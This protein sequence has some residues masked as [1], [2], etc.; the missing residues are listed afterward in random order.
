MFEEDLL[1]RRIRGFDG[2][3]ES[4]NLAPGMPGAILLR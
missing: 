4:F 2:L 3:R 1:L